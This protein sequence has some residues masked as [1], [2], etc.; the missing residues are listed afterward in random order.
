[1]ES[2]N[3]SVQ[4][5]NDFAG[6]YANRFMNIDSYKDSID[7]FCDNIDNNSPFILE[8]A[9]GPGNVTRY[10]RTRYPYSNITA[11][12]LAPRMI[13]I[14]K[15]NVNDVDFRVM[16]VR[17]INSLANRFDLVMC[18]FCLPFLSKIDTSKLIKDCYDRLN[19]N[20]RLYISTMEGEECDAGFES[21][22]FSGDS[23]IY[24]N[25]H[26]QSDLENALN[27]AGFKI[28]YFKRQPYEESDGSI[29]NDLI[30]IGIKN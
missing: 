18:S 19:T 30:L 17:K 24:F 1:M 27:I 26:S 6:E 10:L 13:E 12:D 14:A 2:F 23:E 7:K 20:G 21:T 29:T 3:I 8:L 25:Y 5:F 11:I 16:D 4:R 9:C 22:S 28:D 15:K